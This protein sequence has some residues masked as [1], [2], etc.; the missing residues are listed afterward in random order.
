MLEELEH[1]TAKIECYESS[2]R[3]SFFSRETVKLAHG[4]F[5]KAETFYLITSH[6]GCNNDGERDVYM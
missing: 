6:E 3:L 2:V 1:H 4:E 5:M